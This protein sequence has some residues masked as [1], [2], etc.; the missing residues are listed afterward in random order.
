MTHNLC[1]PKIREWIFFVLLVF[2]RLDEEFGLPIVVQKIIL[3]SMRRHELG[4]PYIM[5]I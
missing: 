3:K 1:H 2:Q 5:N 4:Y